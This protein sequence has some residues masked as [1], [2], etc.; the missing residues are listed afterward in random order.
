M[1]KEI[2]DALGG[3]EDTVKTMEK[4]LL[5][6][7][8][9]PFDIE[10]N[11]QDEIYSNKK[12]SKNGS[13]GHAQYTTRSEFLR[14]TLSDNNL[15]EAKIVSVSP[16]RAVLRRMDYGNGPP[17]TARDSND[18]DSGSEGNFDRDQT[19]PEISEM[20]GVKL[21]EVDVDAN[22]KANGSVQP[23]LDGTGMHASKISQ[24]L[25]DESMTMRLNR[26]NYLKDFL[27]NREPAPVPNT[28]QVNTRNENLE[29][30]NL[31]VASG[32][33]LDNPNLGNLNL[34]FNS[35]SSGGIYQNKKGEN[36]RM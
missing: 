30:N 15:K 18:S 8:M 4:S 29:I 9:R 22:E 31:N 12:A 26:D 28:A 6:H 20:T 23:Y 25:N 2:I 35:T 16:Y 19:I 21:G 3:L 34:K 10:P 11:Y 5:E 36:I 13:P 7:E 14:K 17:D 1:S 24:Q 33:S 27:G 32:N